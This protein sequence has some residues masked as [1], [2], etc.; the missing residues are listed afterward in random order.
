MNNW[1]EKRQ[2]QTNFTEH[3]K[4]N[5]PKPSKEDSSNTIVTEQQ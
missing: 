3:S 2:R 4:I 1:E 5:V